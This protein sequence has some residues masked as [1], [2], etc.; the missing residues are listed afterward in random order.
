MLHVLLLFVQ[1]QGS[2]S[3][4]VGRIETVTQNI[5]SRNSREYRT[6]IKATGKLTKAVQDHI[7]PI[8]AELVANDLITPE[9]Q[10][11]LRNAQRP[12]IERAADLVTLITGKV[13]QNPE[14]YHTFVKILKEDK[15]TFKDVLVLLEFS[16]D[17]SP[18]PGPGI[19]II[20]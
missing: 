18:P 8:C 13:E 17:T 3:V 16:D 20:T 14:N 12:A 5:M 4:A 19:I 11:A 6:L 9:N 7:T 10:A 15:A 1:G 2:T